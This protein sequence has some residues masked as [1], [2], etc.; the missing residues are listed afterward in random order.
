M[1]TGGWLASISW[2][3]EVDPKDH[4]IAEAA[5]HGR[6]RESGDCKRGNAALDRMQLWLPKVLRCVS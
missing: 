6:C 5:E 3:A 1:F 2:S 4:Y